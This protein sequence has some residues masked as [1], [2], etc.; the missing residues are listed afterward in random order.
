MTAAK[1]LL[2]VAQLTMVVA[3]WAP[4]AAGATPLTAAAD[5]VRHWQAP[6]GVV[7]AQVDT[8][9]D[10]VTVVLDGHGQQVRVLLTHLPPTAKSGTATAQ[11]LALTSLLW[12]TD[13]RQPT[14]VWDATLASLRTHIDKADT[15]QFAATRRSGT[16]PPV[17]LV[18][19]TW[20]LLALSIPALALTLH[21]SLRTLPGRKH[22]WLLLIIGAWLLRAWAPHRLVMVHFGY[23]HVDQAAFLHELP[24]Y[25]PATTLLDHALF[26]LAP[27]DHRSVQWAHTII[28]TLTL[29]PLAAL[30][31][32]LSSQ[33]LAP[34]FV[35][36]ALAVL[37]L[38]ILDHGSESMLVPALL[39]WAM[40]TVGL[41]EF[42]GTGR[43]VG[44]A[45]AVIL[46]TL[47]GLSRPDC[48]V[49]AA[50]T[51]LL[52]VSVAVGRPC[53]TARWPAL[54]LAALALAV[55]AIP[56]ALYL[57]ERATEDV[58]LGNL[59]R[60]NVSFFA[61]LPQRLLHGWVVLDP[62]YFPLPLLA[63]A[64][65]G[66]GVPVCRKAALGLWAAAVLWALPMLLD[67]NETSKLRLMMPSALV[68][69]MA[70]GLGA[71]VL[72]ERIGALRRRWAVA[73]MGALTA[74]TA[75]ATLPVVI[76]P[77]LSDFSENA[78]DAAVKLASDGKPTALVVRA[79]VDEPAYGIHLYW[80]DSALEAT[81][82]WLS[83]ADWQAGR[84][85]P[86]ET[87]LGVLDV[88]CWAAL[89][90]RRSF[91]DM[92]PACTAMAQHAGNAVAWRETVVN[93]GERGFR[94]YES[95]AKRPVLEQK[96]VQLRQ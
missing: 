36:L 92:H 29:L 70:A 30:T 69:V 71:G 64:A 44:L 39:W 13:P 25:G 78:V 3:A 32:R 57:R 75:L 56:D 67:F 31:Q 72:S 55:L 28:G 54:A 94:W 86:D 79:Y 24:R 2:A 50:P 34:W 88:R 46:L 62:R 73:G 38:A 8:G 1:W 26:W 19:Q 42:L 61:E 65:V 10:M 22:W 95:A 18:W 63:L 91:A 96:V 4:T 85:R 59:P 74:V 11:G 66:L 48:L 9:A 51:A 5:A 37:P 14:P 45:A 15:G 84:L 58:A 80:P 33:T 49:V 93:V 40:A 27:V 68:V 35:A 47:C 52:V 81:D 60:L 7:V 21:W 90:D 23:L 43:R 41:V 12:L 17:L 83:V 6:T 77:Q 89:P 16:A 53:L 76:A 82:R 20:L 87:A